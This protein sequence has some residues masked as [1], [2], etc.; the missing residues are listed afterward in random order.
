M[1]KMTSVIGSQ[2]QFRYFKLVRSLCLGKSLSVG[3]HKVILSDLNN[4]KSYFQKLFLL[5][6]LHWC[7]YMKSNF[8]KMQFDL[9]L[10]DDFSLSFFFFFK[11]TPLVT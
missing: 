1:S 6:G 11:Y 7:E 4:L 10:W 9:P 2:C 5:C 8:W 3:L